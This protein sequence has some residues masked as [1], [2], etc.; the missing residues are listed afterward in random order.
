MGDFDLGFGG[1]QREPDYDARPQGG[2]GRH[3]YQRRRQGFTPPYDRSPVQTPNDWYGGGV[4][5]TGGMVMVRRW[6]T[7]PDDALYLVHD[8]RPHRRVEYEVAYGSEPGVSLQ[9][10]EWVPEQFSDG[11]GAYMFDGVVAERTVRRNTDAAKARAARELMREHA[12][13]TR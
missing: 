12:G 8:E 1:P 2:E 9:R 11:T 3:D 10:Y 13:K 7:A 5:Q 4:A 6:S